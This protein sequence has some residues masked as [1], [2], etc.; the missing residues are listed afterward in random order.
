LSE[1]TPR[2]CP[3][4]GGGGPFSALETWRDPV[5]G[6]RYELW[7][8]PACGVVFSEPRRAPPPD[9]YE[10]AAPLRAQE[11]RAP[12][13][14]DQ[15]FALFFDEG[16]RPGKILDVGCGDGGFLALAQAHG[17]TGVG[18][19]YEKRMIA[20]ARARGVEAHASEFEAFC[21][22]RASDE[23]D[24]ITLF[25]V[26]EHT[27]EPAELLAL[28][29]PLLKKGGRVAITLPN[30][31][32]PLPLV[33]EEH[34]YP[35][36]HFTRWTPAALAGFLE[37]NGFSIE[38]QDARTLRL[39]YLSDHLYFHAFMPFVL[40]A[41]KRLLFGKTPPG[42]T[43]TELYESSGK[44]GVLADKASRQR[45]VDAVKQIARLVT[46]PLAACL[47]LFY[48]ATMPLPG[49]SLYTLARRDS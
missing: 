1:G 22:S 30:A 43:V 34:D 40:G 19:D 10:K 8:C 13:E 47:W 39:A 21:R 33:R 24:A 16:L 42:T 36:H 9:W 5:A 32:R 46:R 15:R 28:I 18:F 37:R 31:L 49:D 11:R 35:P 25:D 4:C 20:I 14:T 26:L 23:F 45:L 2:G 41:A 29:K 38:H 44:A 3:A 48:R 17:W 6:G 7:S 27:P 12:P